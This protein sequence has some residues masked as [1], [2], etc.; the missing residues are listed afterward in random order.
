MAMVI[1]I[2]DRSMEDSSFITD[3]VDVRYFVDNT[4]NEALRPF[5]TEYKWV[6]F[7]SEGQLVSSGIYI[8]D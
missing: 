6:V 5:V 7:Y 4:V 3:P 1:P 2:D 8:F